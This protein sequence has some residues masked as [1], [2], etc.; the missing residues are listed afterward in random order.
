M[1]A[2]LGGIPVRPSAQTPATEEGIR[3]IREY[4]PDRSLEAERV[5]T[6]SPRRPFLA[7]DNEDTTSPTCPPNASEKSS[8]APLLT[9]T[10]RRTVSVFLSSLKFYK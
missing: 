4:V 8:D 5:A 7:V 3:I 10:K 6:M 1:S 2:W 9:G